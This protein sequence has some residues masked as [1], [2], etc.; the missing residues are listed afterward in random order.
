MPRK[1]HHREKRR[2]QSKRERA[3]SMPQRLQT[4]DARGWYPSTRRKAA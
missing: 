2:Q 1:K 4:P 3:R